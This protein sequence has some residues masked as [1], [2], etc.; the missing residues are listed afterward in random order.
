MK[1]EFAVIGDIHGEIRSLERAIDRI[2]DWPA[3][4]IFA[5]DYVNRGAHSREV[6]D[7]LVELKSDLGVRA[8]FL[9]GNHDLALLDFLNGAPHSSL[10]GHGGLTTLNS[11]IGRNVS[12]DPF[13]QMRD[14]FP[15]TH[16][17]FLD[18][19]DVCWETP[20][21][22][23]AHAGIDPARPASRTKEDLVLGSHPSLF[24]PGVRLPKLVVSGHY[25][26]RNGRPFM[27]DKFV[28]VDSGCGAVP[29]APLSIVFFPSRQV[30]S[31]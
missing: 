19:L 5:G 18:E 4:V 13:A 3:T 21:V 8:N 9:L 30:V 12:D 15:A 26:Q 2:R 7:L 20:E 6:L 28:C 16:R 23:I 27:S 1:S 31:I 24:E 17:R 29:G 10:L 14:S 25:V 22:L 11:Y